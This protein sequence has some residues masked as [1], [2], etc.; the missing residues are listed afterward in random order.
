MSRA[1]CLNL[2]GR[3]VFPAEAERLPADRNG[4]R[5]SEAVRAGIRGSDAREWDTTEASA[6]SDLPPRRRCYNHR[7]RYVYHDVQKDRHSNNAG[8]EADVV[9]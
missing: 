2:A 8:S 4:W 1:I 7:P 6:P 5:Q 3:D 9:T